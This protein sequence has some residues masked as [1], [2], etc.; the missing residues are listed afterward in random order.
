M[1]SNWKTEQFMV[2]NEEQLEIITILWQLLATIS[3]ISSHF[4]LFYKNNSCT[5]TELD[6]FIVRPFYLLLYLIVLFPPNS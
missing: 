2:G 5:H 6:S 4:N 1:K 3:C